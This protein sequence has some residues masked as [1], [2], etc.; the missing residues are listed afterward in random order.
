M[1]GAIYDPEKEIPF[2]LC[3]HVNSLEQM[4]TSFASLRVQ[5]KGGENNSAHLLHSGW[6]MKAFHYRAEDLGKQI[7]WVFIHFCLNKAEQKTQ[8]RK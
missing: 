4:I 1:H 5:R 3:L 6:E 2:S 7:I 8:L